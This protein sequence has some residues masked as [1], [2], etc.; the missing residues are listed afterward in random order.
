MVLVFGLVL[1]LMTG[2]QQRIREEAAPSQWLGFFSQR[3]GNIE[4]FVARVDSDALVQLTRFEGAMLD[5][6]DLQWSPTHPWMAI[7][8]LFGRASEIV[9]ARLGSRELINVSNHPSGDVGPVW[10][11]NGRWLA[12]ISYRDGEPQIYIAR[13]DG[14]GLQPLLPSGVYQDNPIWSPDGRRIAFLTLQG[15]QWAIQVVSVK[16]G[17]SRVI[18]PYAQPL[19]SGLSWSPDGNWLAFAALDGE[20][21]SVFVVHP[22][23]RGLLNVSRN[24]DYSCDSPLWSAHSATLTFSCYGRG[25]GLYLTTVGQGAPQKLVDAVPEVYDWSFDGQRLVYVQFV[26]GLREIFVQDITTG[27]TVQIGA[28]NRN[29]GFPLWSADDRYLL[30]WSDR[31]DRTDIYVMRPDGTDLRNISQHPTPDY[32]PRWGP[33]LVSLPWHPERWRIVGGAFVLIALGGMGL[34]GW[35]GPRKGAGR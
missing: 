24:A 19:Y 2:W 29:N 15:T 35:R 21:A 11:P 22:D 7:T 14:E 6:S 30:F 13:A 28:S 20:E 12:F 10:S 9:V 17:A 31:D 1:L 27:E 8:G 34:A 4:I 33:A 5:S 23:G 32:Y 26:N 3:T 18:V 16:D 25:A